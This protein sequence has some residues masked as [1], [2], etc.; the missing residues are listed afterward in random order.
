[1]LSCPP[2]ARTP[3]SLRRTGDAREAV[4]Q[5]GRRHRVSRRDGA[6]RRHRGRGPR[7]PAAL[8]E[9]RPH[10]SVGLRRCHRHARRLRASTASSR[11][12]SVSAAAPAGARPLHARART[13][14]PVDDGQ[15]I[16]A[17]G[18]VR[19]DR[20]LTSPLGGVACAAYDYRMFV[21]TRNSKGGQDETPVYWGYAVQPFA[22]DSRAR[23]YPVAGT[24][25]PGE[26]TERLTGDAAVKR[27]R[28]YVRSTG[29]ETVEYRMLGALDTV[30]QRVRENATTG[31]PPGFRGA[32]RHGAGR[33]APAARGI[34]AA[35]RGHRVGVRHLVGFARG[36]RRP[37]IAAARVVRGDRRRRARGARRQAGRADLDDGLRRRRVRDD[38]ARRRPVL[39]RD[40]C[41]PDR[42]GR[43]RRGSTSE[44]RPDH[45]SVVGGSLHRTVDGS[46]S[47][48]RPASPSCRR[49]PCVRWSPATPARARRRT[50]P[51]PGSS[52]SSS[53]RVTRS[54]SK[55]SRS[56]AARAIASPASARAS[57][58]HT[59]ARPRQRA[60]V[61]RTRRLRK[62]DQRQ[63][64]VGA[65]GE[66]RAV[67]A[68]VEAGVGLVV[69]HAA[70]PPAPSPVRNTSGTSTARFIANSAR[71]A[72]TACV[73]RPR[74][75]WP[76]RRDAPRS[77]PPS[78]PPS[79]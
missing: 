19:A 79:G 13:D 76:C 69:L 8:P 39:A 22:I 30:L 17:T 29:W 64:V 54:K 34:G 50:S 32:E 36:D 15:P 70:A 43:S 67:V 52:I 23:S 7:L 78:C 35:G 28:D 33:G 1:M 10:R 24:L 56:T 40:D 5:P 68:V 45:A 66:H 20:P 77:S 58:A 74:R 75:R 3:D 21:H 46:G 44:H 71:R 18:V 73:R 65:I 12:P 51:R 31:S 57:S 62:G 37:A 47:R 48:A 9:R 16:I 38:R 6:V 61:A 14:G 53:T 59:P 72:G 25:L 49:P 60:H 63:H 26:T 27:A 55:P 42:P 41:H 4:V 11:S 2:V